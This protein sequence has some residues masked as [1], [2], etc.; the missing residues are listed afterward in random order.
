MKIVIMGAGISGHTAALILKRKLESQHEVIV[1]SPN[2]KW[3]WIP[4]NI[5]VGVGKMSSEDVTFPLAPVYQRKGIKFIQAKAIEIYPEGDS[6]SPNPFVVAE[7]TADGTLGQKQKITYDYL[8][9]A[10][11]PRLK[12][13]ATEGLGP[14]KF[15]YSVCT[16]LHASECY[17]ALSKHIAEMKK[18]ASRTFVVGVGHGTCTCE[19]AAFEYVFN[20]EFLLRSEGVRNKA[21]II[22]LTNEAELADFGV[23]GMQ[24]KEGGHTTPGKIFAESLYV[25]RGIDWILGAHVRK[26]TQSQIEYEDLQGDIHLL[27]Y[28]FAMLLPPF[29]G[30]PLKAFDRAGQDISGRLFNAAGFMKV[31]ADYTV[32]DYEQWL[33]SDWPKTYQTEYKNL[34]TIGIAFAPPHQ[35]S[36]PR[37]NKNGTLIT[38]APP[39]TGMPSAVMGRTVATSIVD[40]INSGKNIPSRSASMAELGAACIASAGAHPFKGSA[41]SI[42]IYPLVPD[43]KKYPGIGRSRSYTTGE[44]GLAGHWIKYLLHYAFMYKAKANPLW[45]II[46]E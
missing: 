6:S 10:T 11:G 37:K 18:G 36:R 28:D 19:G 39:R 24:L 32:K 13:E 16:Y 5:W 45:W 40:M 15:T 27:N 42:T 21:K 17:K 14:G 31:D 41:A 29:G 26:V 43:F 7:S 25:E 46:P 38:P 3:N 2:S 35:I 34:F 4:S 44:I 12:F 22:Y 1:I 9:N 33:P 23:D 8:I 20:L 30:V